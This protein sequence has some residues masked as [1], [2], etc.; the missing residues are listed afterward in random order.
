M[1]LTLLAWLYITWNCFAW[2]HLLFRLAGRRFLLPDRA[3]DPGITCLT[4]LLTIG[5]LASWASLFTALD[6]F[7]HAIVLG[8]TIGWTLGRTN[9]RFL[10][11]SILPLKTA[12]SSWP[13]GALLAACLLLVLV[14]S[15]YEIKHPDTLI[16]HAQAIHWME[17]YKAVPGL[18]HLDSM[19][20]MANLWFT[21]MAMFR[22]N[23]LGAHPFLF[24]NG[25][26][27]CWFFGFIGNRLA[28][29]RT[30]N[31]YHWQETT[32]WLLLLVFSLLSWTQVR[33]TAASA[34]PDFIVSLLCWS[35]FYLLL[36]G[37]PQTGNSKAVPLY[38]FLLV[39]FTC[40]AFVSKL[41]TAALVLLPLLVAG[42]LLWQRQ[43]RAFSWLPLTLLLFLLPFCLRNLISAGYPFYPSS[44]MGNWWNP[45]WKYNP[46]KMTIVRE[47]VTAYARDPERTTP[48]HEMA[49]AGPGQWIPVWWKTVAG[50]DQLLLVSLALLLLAF[51]VRWPLKKLDSR[52]RLVLL[53]SGGGSL[54]W[55]WVAPAVR[56]G[57]GFLLPLWYCL[58]LAVWPSRFVKE[59]WEG[60]AA[61]RG[62]AGLLLI[63]SLAASAY[64]IYRVTHY[65]LKDQVWVPA[66]VRAIPYT[67][68]N[69]QGQVFN[70][71]LE[72]DYSGFSPVPVIKDSCQRFRLRDTSLQSGFKANP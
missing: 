59:R 56:F 63:V 23:F 61:L 69:C 46:A 47:Y 24:L 5:M 66:G 53:V 28:A 11:D 40:G 4:G 21:A 43:Y 36:K 18:V 44:F 22:F 14:I 65:Y 9:R 48:V 72:D 55:F 26:V 45:D 6:G 51:L 17:T 52:W 27:L 3:P 71:T 1:L 68:V 2:G 49:T 12:V 25:A 33:L 34:S 64:S 38:L 19:M 57:T 13:I 41:S 37:W 50:V 70:L 39:F 31:G 10:R 62:F 29:S 7:P 58:F 32:G 16:Y 60:R 35:S 42:R 54:I 8:G 15:S 67:P 30:A 20:A